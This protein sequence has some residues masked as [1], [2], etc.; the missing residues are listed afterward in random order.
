MALVFKDVL[1]F[2]GDFDGNG[3]FS[4]WRK[5]VE[6]AVKM[7]MK[8]GIHEKISARQWV[9]TIANQKITGKV[10]AHYELKCF[11]NVY[12]SVKD[13]LDM[14]EVEF[15]DEKLKVSRREDM[16][17]V[18]LLDFESGM[19]YFDAKLVALAK[20]AIKSDD[21]KLSYIKKGLLPVDS[22]YR[23]QTRGIMSID[24]ID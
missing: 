20:A 19:K 10:K 1:N 17:E 6:E 15:G 3:S 18:V 21:E 16:E 8:D 22:V 13:F 4:Y 11:D 24:S 7:P 9:K 12:D 23:S 2:I 14:L 5:D